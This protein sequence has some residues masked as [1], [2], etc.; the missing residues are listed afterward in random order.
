MSNYNENF[1][2]L[3]LNFKQNQKALNH[4]NLNHAAQKC[5]KIKS[6]ASSLTSC[7]EKK[8]LSFQIE[9]FLKKFINLCKKLQGTC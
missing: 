1:D 2:K 4:Y 3:K 7:A 9:T 6:K 8:F 5:M